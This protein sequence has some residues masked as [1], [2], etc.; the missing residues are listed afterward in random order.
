MAN[1]I[2]MCKVIVTFYFKTICYPIT[3]LESQFKTTKTVVIASNLAEMHTRHFQTQVNTITPTVYAQVVTAST[4]K[5]Q[6]NGM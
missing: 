3:C 6:H 2:K 1:C 5:L 4:T